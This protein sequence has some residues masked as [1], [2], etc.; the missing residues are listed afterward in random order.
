MCGIAGWIDFNRNI[1]HEDKIMLKMSEAL[2]PRGPDEHGEYSENEVYFAHRRLIVVD[3]KNGKQP[4]SRRAGDKRYVLCYNGEL[5]NTEDIRKELLEKGCAFEGHSD[6]EVLLNAYMVWGEACVDK[7]NGIF[8]FAV[9]DETKKELFLARDRMGVKPL[10][11]YAYEGGLI[12]SSEIRSLLKHPY[13]KPQI[14]REGLAG[15]MLLGPAKTPGDGVFKGINEVCQASCLKFNRD[16]IFEYEYWHITAKEHTEGFEETAEHTKELLYDSIKRQLVSDVPLCTF[17]S[18]G[19]DSSII[20]AVA[21]KEYK[22]KGE[23]LNT[24]SIDYRFND[25]NFKSSAF[26]PDADAPYVQIM[27][28]SIGSKHHIVELDTPDL[29]E[30]LVDSTY[31]RSLPG[32]A[33]VDSSLYLFCKEIKRDFT[34]A[35]SGECADE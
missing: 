29:T 1:K 33:D 32:M 10:F 28:D 4:M 34:V 13:I 19:L 21:A 35:L 30:A 31:A 6:T 2:A 15:I 23:V 12:F 3:P 9:W 17:L 11:Y 22:D 7:L 18:G 8:A 16:G 24:Y 5:Y 20:S 26:Q 14:T 27:A 25:V